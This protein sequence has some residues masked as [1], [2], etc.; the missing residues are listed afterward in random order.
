MFPKTLKQA[1]G[2]DCVIDAGHSWL[3]HSPRVRALR[4]AGNNRLPLTRRR[5]RR[6]FVAHGIQQAG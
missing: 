5:P 2:F 4:N 6:V 3:G 1:P